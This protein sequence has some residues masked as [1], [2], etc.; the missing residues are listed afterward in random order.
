ML[1][2]EKSMLHNLALTYSVIVLLSIGLLALSHL[3]L[4]LTLDRR[5][6]SALPSDKKY[7]FVA[8][9][10]FG[11]GRAVC[12]GYAAC[13]DWANNSWIIKHHYNGFDIKSFANRFEKILGYLSTITLAIVSSLVCVVPIFSLLGV[14]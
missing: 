6:R 5:V 12:F 14:F 9:W 13:F 4:R 1:V 10:Y 2:K 11:Y 8:D 7:D 3:L